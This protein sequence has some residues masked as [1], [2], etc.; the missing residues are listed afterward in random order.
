M[1]GWD[2]DE[3]LFRRQPSPTMNLGPIYS[4]MKGYLKI[5]EQK[6]KRKKVVTFMRGEKSPPVDG[7]MVAGII[8]VNLVSNLH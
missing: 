5:E 8:S 4:S 1:A 3:F 2:W 7:G 6:T